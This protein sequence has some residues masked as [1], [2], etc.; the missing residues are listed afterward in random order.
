ML[1]DMRGGTSTSNDVREMRVDELQ[2][3]AVT[4]ELGY[5]RGETRESSARYE[6]FRRAISERDEAAW[7][8]VIEL[9]RRF[10][11]AQARRRLVPGTSVQ[12]GRYYVDRAFER[13]WRGTRDGRFEQFENL[14]SILKY[15]TLCLASEVIDQARARRRHAWVPLDD[16]ICG[17]QQ[18]G[19]NPEDQIIGQLARRELW[20]AINRELV[21]DAERIVA[22]L[23]FVA[24]L[25]PREIQ[26]LH[27]DTFLSA[28]DI[29]RVKRNLIERLRRS[30]NIRG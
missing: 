19:G 25:S 21:D 7:Q 28:T 10:L 18:V 15:L 4:Q 17:R 29:Y 11:T 27:P 20:Q 8:V 26:A 16:E 14:A 9:Y 22:R 5:Q 6:L 24:G 3:Q 23:S 30:P 12:D 2:A 1:A 13:F